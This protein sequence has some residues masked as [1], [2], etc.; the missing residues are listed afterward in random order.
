MSNILQRTDAVFFAHSLA[1]CFRSSLYGAGGRPSRIENFQK[2]EDFSSRTIEEYEYHANGKNKQRI[3]TEYGEDGVTA[4]SKWV[5]EYDEFGDEVKR[6]EISY[7][8]SSEVI[9][10]V[11][12]STHTREYRYGMVVKRVTEKITYDAQNNPQTKSIYVSKYSGNNA[13]EGIREEYTYI[14]GEWVKNDSLM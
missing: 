8:N 11:S 7:E 14:D 4:T 10:S 2:T 13:A 5:S 3:C 9:D 12:T 1:A 6:T